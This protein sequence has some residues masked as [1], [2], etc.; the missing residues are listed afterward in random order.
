MNLWNVSLLSLVLVLKYAVSVVADFSM[1]HFLFSV[2]L[3]FCV[4]LFRPWINTITLLSLTNIHK[5][6]LFSQTE[7]YWCSHWCCCLKL[8]LL[9]FLIY[10]SMSIFPFAIFVG[11][12]ISC[13]VAIIIFVISLLSECAFFSFFP[14]AFNRIYFQHNHWAWWFLDFKMIYFGLIPNK[15]NVSY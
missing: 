3:F 2:H 11:F 14:I 8:M 15:F 7:T 1:T 10:L 5:I 9:Q 6:S 13:Y 12:D 4:G